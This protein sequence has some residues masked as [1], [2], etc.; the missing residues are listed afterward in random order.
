MQHP[1]YCPFCKSSDCT[2]LEG[3]GEYFVSYYVKCNHCNARGSNFV[4]LVEDGSD[5]AKN[6]AIKHWN[7]NDIRPNTICHTVK[8]MITQ[9]RYDLTTLWG[10]Y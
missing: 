5:D 6:V 10:R 1:D 3:N 2:L 7:Q 4:E 8:R 9:L